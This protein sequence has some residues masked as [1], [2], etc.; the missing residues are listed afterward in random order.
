MNKALFFL[1]TALFSFMAHAE[2]WETAT[3]PKTIV[4]K[5]I[6]QVLFDGKN[7]KV[8]DKIEKSGLLE[9]REK[10]LVQFKVEAYNNIISV[11]PSSKMTFNPSS[12]K[13]YILDEGMCRWKTDI[14]NSLKEHAKGKVF[15]KTVSMG[16]RGTDFLIKSNPLFGEVEIIMLD[17]E[18]LMENLQDADNSVLVKKGQW[19]G[20]GG[21][22]GKKIA[23]P[24]EIPATALAD[25]EKLIEAP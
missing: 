10:S 19:G 20:M 23:P 7:L 2:D 3:P 22:Y 18:V 4:H 1:F 13:K 8:G 17:G 9:T 14:K 5:I 15:T 12:E 16:V 21:R 24:I 6:G 25:F 11:G